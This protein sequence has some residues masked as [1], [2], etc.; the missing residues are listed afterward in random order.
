MRILTEISWKTIRCNYKFHLCDL[1]LLDQFGTWG[2]DLITFHSN[3]KN[4]SLLS[5]QIRLP[6][7]TTVKRLSVDRLDLFFLR[8]HLFMVYNKLEDRML[9]SP[10][11]FDGITGFNSNFFKLI[12]K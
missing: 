8:N 11:A 4:Y 6:N 7:M 10:A 5:I 3:F 2:I 1:Y 9:W 12:L